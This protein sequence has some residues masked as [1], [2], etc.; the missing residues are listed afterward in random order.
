[1]PVVSGR[2]PDIHR[3]KLLVCLS[4]CSLRQTRTA[5]PYIISV[6]L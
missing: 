2:L 5:D 1:M 3:D 4:T 6:V